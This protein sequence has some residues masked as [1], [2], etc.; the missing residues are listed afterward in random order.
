MFHTSIQGYYRY[1]KLGMKMYIVNLNLK[2]IQL[3]SPPLKTPP[4]TN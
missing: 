3:T 4:K 1:I 2:K